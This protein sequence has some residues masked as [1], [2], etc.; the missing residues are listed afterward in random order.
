LA[1]ASYGGGLVR[2]LLLRHGESVSNADPEAVALPEAEG[3]RLTPRGREQAEAAARWLARLEIDALV[4]S[5]MGRA[6]ETA[7]AIAARTGLEIE[8]DDEI[9]ELRESSDFLDLPPEEQKLRRW[10][11][12]MEA[13]GDD[14]DWAPPGGESFNVVVGRVRRFKARLD[15]RDPESTVLA[16]SHGIFARFFLVHS[17][18]EERFRASDSR[19][20]WQ[21]RTVNCGLSDFEPARRRHPADP[22]LEGWT[23]LSW[24]CRPWAFPP[25]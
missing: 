15:A 23:C 1:N 21:L 9:H 10:S 12:W 3:D 18:L 16:V 19:R 25:S 4:S 7:E 6:R 13:H 17:L 24:M 5:P 8:I 20:L 14:P 22:E 11:V 2:L